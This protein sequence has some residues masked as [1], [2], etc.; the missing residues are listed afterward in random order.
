VIATKAGLQRP[1]PDRWEPDCRP[2]HLRER[3]EGSLLRLKVDRID[4]FQLHRIDSK[5]PVEDQIGAMLELQKEGKVRHLGLSEVTVE[6]IETVRRL[7]EIATVQN[8]YNLSD[9]HSEAVLEYCTREN[10]GFIPWFPL[11]TG[12]LAGPG[13]PLSSAA[14]RLD[15]SPG[16]VALAWLLK[17][18]PVML[19]IPGTSKVSHLESNAEAAL[20]KIDDEMARELDG[21]RSGAA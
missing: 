14:R 10:I 2:A 19:P 21:M 1:G 15:A 6:Q 13:S 20:L 4:L 8:L 18:S 3:C 9:R 17:K 12:N 5:V 7:G 16:Q 11:A